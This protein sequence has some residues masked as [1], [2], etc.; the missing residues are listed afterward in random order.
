MITLIFQRFFISCIP[1]SISVVNIQLSSVMHA[2]LQ[3]NKTPTRQLLKAIP[4]YHGTV[5]MCFPN[6]GHCPTQFIFN[7]VS[8]A[9]ISCYG[10]MST[11]QL[12]NLTEI[13]NFILCGQHVYVNTGLRT[14]RAASGNIPSKL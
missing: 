11:S 1:C 2:L 7:N 14:Q 6:Y 13:P 9:D 5:Y 10:L 3:S 12:L 4:L 8:C